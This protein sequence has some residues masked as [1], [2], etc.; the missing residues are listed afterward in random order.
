MIDINKK[1]T[2]LERVSLR[3]THWIGS[4][5]SLILHTIAFGGF[6][7]LRYMGLVPNG[8]LLILTAAVC[9][10][11]IYLVIF[12]QM[13]VR[14]NTRSLIE[15]QMIIEQI[16]QEENETHKLMINLLHVTHQVKTIQQDIDTLKKNAVSKSSGNG[17][18]RPKIL[19]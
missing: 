12:I 16:Q 2:Y 7:I 4:P 3:L 5:F 1:L 19:H 18:N 17:S 14:K 13:M 8:V 6:F 10:E 9:L 11:A 15:A